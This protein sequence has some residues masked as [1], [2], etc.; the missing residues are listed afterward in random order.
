MKKREYD[1]I[2]EGNGV[3]ASVIN[4]FWR[5][6]IVKIT[7]TCFALL[8]LTGFI[9]IWNIKD[10]LLDCKNNQVF[11]NKDEMYLYGEYAKLFAGIVFAFAINGM[12]W[13]A[14]A[15]TCL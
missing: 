14:V 9:M 13:Y 1:K 7:V 15:K 4:W 11:F 8:F 6:L 12:A 10:L 3:L 5:W 2:I